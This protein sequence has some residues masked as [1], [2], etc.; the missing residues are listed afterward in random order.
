MYVFVSYS[1]ED[2]DITRSITKILKKYHIE[3]FLDEKDIEWGGN[4]NEEISLAIKKATHLITI[5]SPASINSQWVAYEI[6]QAKARGT[7]VLPYLTHPSLNLPDFI[8]YLKYNK[9]LEDLDRFFDQASR[10]VV[11]I[12]KINDT[13]LHGSEKVLSL[14]ARIKDKINRLERIPTTDLK[15]LD[16]VSSS[17]TKVL[18]EYNRIPRSKKDINKTRKFIVENDVVKK[19]DNLIEG[20]T[21]V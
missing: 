11:L 4:I 18:K 19:I 5:I 15:E 7:K 3:Y 10:N 2:K 17:I 12:G 16:R 9:S 14:I 20:E 13:H 6:G 21:N 8:R 1:H